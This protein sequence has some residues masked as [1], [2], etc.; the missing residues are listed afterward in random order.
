MRYADYDLK[1][2]MLKIVPTNMTDT[3]N[4]FFLHVR[5]YVYKHMIRH[6]TQNVNLDNFISH[7]P[8]T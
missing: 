3:Y 4:V 8:S 1:K 6:I 7:I 2:M 5:L